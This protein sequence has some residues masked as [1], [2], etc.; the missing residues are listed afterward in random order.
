MRLVHPAVGMRGSMAITTAGL[1]DKGYTPLHP[2]RP[3]M[4]LI[5]VADEKR[6]KYYCS[7]CRLTIC[8]SDVGLC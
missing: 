4:G 3:V 6:C 1:H 2:S 7:M 8:S 5:N